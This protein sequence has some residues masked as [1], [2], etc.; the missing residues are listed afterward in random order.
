MLSVSPE[1]QGGG[2]GRT[3][4]AAAEDHARTD[5]GATAMEMTVIERRAEL[6]AWYERVGYRRT[7]ELR[8]FPYVP[9]EPVDFA[10]VVLERAL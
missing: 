4:I 9:A 5:W 2:L 8:P 3:L 1:L 6:I 10:M 7:G